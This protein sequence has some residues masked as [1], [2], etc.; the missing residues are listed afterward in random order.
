MPRRSVAAILLVAAAAGA[1]GLSRSD[2]GSRATGL[3]AAEP[4][5]PPLLGVVTKRQ[6]ALLV[7][8]DP[9]S[10]RPRPGARVAVGSEACAPRSGGSACWGVPPWSYSP[11]RSL[12]AVARHEAGVVRSVRI[13]DVARMR[14]DAEVPILG[15]AVG[16]LAWQTPERVLA[17]QEV[18][19]DERQDL[20]VIDPTR[21]RVIARHALGGTVLRAARTPR[22]LVLLLAPAKAIGP[23]RVAIVDQRGAVRIANLERLLAGIQPRDDA[24]YRLEQPGLAVDSDGHR[25]FVVGNGLVA[26]LDLASLAVSYHPL[27]HPVSLLGRLRSWFASDAYA[28]GASGAA[29]SAV[30]LGG[31]TLAVAGADEED[32]RVRPAGLSLIDTHRWKVRTID[33]AATDIRVASGLL[34]ATGSAAGL[35]AYGFDGT[36]RFRIR[37]GRAAWIEQVFDGRA[38]VGGMRPDGRPA[39]LRV[40]DLA[41]GRTV[42]RRAAPLPFLLLDPA[43][44][45]WDG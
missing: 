21:H 32:T 16:L 5:Y 29:R 45:P 24:R 23:A 26:E 10:L 12:L 35:V 38:Y 31:D 11:D 18:C 7:R 9:D 8:V 39:P 4:P 25:A 27:T 43:S 17:V 22:E 3:P 40:V 42:A 19:C 37:E 15:G 30:W 13:V 20:L 6:E 44:G 14:V 41:T 28:K 1:I 33:A 34:L 2:T 36:E